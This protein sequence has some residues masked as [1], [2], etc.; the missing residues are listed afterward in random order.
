MKNIEIYYYKM[1][2]QI[3]KMIIYSKDLIEKVVELQLLNWLQWV[4]QQLQILIKNQNH[5]YHKCKLIFHNI[6]I[7]NNNNNRKK[8]N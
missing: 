5:L 3:F 1:H 4:Q 8:N 6:I 7:H 2:N